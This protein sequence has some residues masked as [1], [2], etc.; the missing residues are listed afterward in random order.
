MATT[1]EMPA[2]RIPLRG[3][4]RHPRAQAFIDSPAKRRIARAG[5]RGGKTTAV[6]RLCLDRFLAG[7]R[8][9]YAVPTA[10]QL[11]AWWWEVKRAL[12][13]AVEQG[14]LYQNQS[15]HLIELSGTKQRIRGKTAWNADTLRGDTA[16]LLV[17]DEWQ[18]MDEEAW[19][20]VG[21]PMLLDHDGD[22][23]FI[24]TPPSLASKSTSKAR[25]PRHAARMYEAA[26]RD[27]TG[28]WSAHHWTSADNPYIS[29][30]AIARASR[31]M[32]SI[33]YQQEILAEEIDDI[34]GALWTRALLEETRRGEI[35]PL[36]RVYV[37]VDPPG[38][39]TECGI[40]VAGV[41]NDG[42]GYVLEDASLLASPEAWASAAVDAYERHKADELIAESNYGGDMVEST[43]RQVVRHRQRVN[44]RMVS[45]T[46]G[47]EIRAQPVAA[48]YER[49]RVHHTGVYPN[50]E[51]EMTGWKPGDKPSPNRMDALVWALW[52][53]EPHITRPAVPAPVGRA[54]A[55]AWR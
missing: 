4:S 7:H 41:G 3:F 43:V 24:Y 13:N 12:G 19:E 25:D 50:L 30:E 6:A 20:R 35:P 37:G 45:A 14:A 16:D 44:V 40:V 15:L 36:V 52:A 31:S 18:L 32:T 23:A 17:L 26:S 11:D 29:H 1:A 10:E 8:V 22:A 9:L 5:R 33:A 27:T 21:E 51:M 2:R 28:L 38:G 55:S 46:R 54:K 47:K 39:A 34:P 48:L 42:H 49:G 53:C